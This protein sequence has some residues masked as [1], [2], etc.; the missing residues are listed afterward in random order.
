MQLIY[1]IHMNV[2]VSSIN[3]QIRGSINF[4]ETSTIYVGKH[5]FIFKIISICD[6]LKI[7]FFK[8]GEGVIDFFCIHHNDQAI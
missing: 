7:N 5:I 8:F 3:K 4:W 2:I 1:K 6:E